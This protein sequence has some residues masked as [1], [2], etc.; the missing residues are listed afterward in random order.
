MENQSEPKSL[1]IDILSQ[2][3]KSENTEDKEYKFP[4]DIIEVYSKFKNWL[5]E[6]GAIYP[7]IEFPIAYLKGKLI[8]CKSNKKIKENKAILYIPYKLIID[9]SKIEMN[10]TLPSLNKYN[11]TKIAYFLMKEFDKGDKSF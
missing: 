7:N 4:K 6:N 10:T 5:N 2:L 1:I 9:S 3:N 11:S 8:G